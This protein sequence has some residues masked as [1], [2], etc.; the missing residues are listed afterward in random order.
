MATNYFN[1]DTNIT[2]GHC[3]CHHLW[4]EFKYRYVYWHKA[5]YIPISEVMESQTNMLTLIGTHFCRKHYM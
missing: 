5:K 1:G 4:M 3:K 2:L